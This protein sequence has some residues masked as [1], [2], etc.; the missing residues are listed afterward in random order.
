M[1]LYLENTT[2][3]NSDPDSLRFQIKILEKSG[4]GHSTCIPEC[5]TQLPIK[6]SLASAREEAKMI[7]FSVVGELLEKNHLNP[8]LVDILIL[9]NSLFC[10]I[11]SLTAMVVNRFHMRS[12]IM[13]FNLSGMGC[14]AGMT[15]VGLARD[16][17]MVHRNS[18]ALVVST[19]ILSF[20]W[21]C[22]KIHS[23]LLTNCIFRM[24]GAAILLS[25]KDQD[26]IN[27]KYV[28]QQL[29]RTNNASDDQSYRSVFQDIDSEGKVGVSLSREITQAAG[30]VL[31]AN[32]ASLGRM[33]L[34]FSEQLRY[35]WS[36]TC[37]KLFISTRRS[38]LYVP[39]FKKAFQHFCIHAG[40]KAVIKA[41]GERLRLSDRDLEASKMTLYRFGNTS[42]SSVWYELCYIE[43]K[44]KIKRGDRVWMITFG[45]GFK[46]NSA[47]WKCISEVRSHAEN[48]WSDIHLYPVDIPDVLKMN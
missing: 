11:P 31:K 33:V 35:A 12:N 17:L 41:T 19:E 15:S 24:G 27:A 1:S 40:G 42:S 5:C 16:L 43:A 39:N 28:L 30:H 47:V 7:I 29:V 26:Q 8:E 36:L 9:N 23:M 3:S 20:N 2:L 34:P 44:G 22:G 10:P 18:L 45:S 13:S 14:S 21:Y 4:Y 38:T 25:N 6:N 48:V 37:Q 46:C 32:I